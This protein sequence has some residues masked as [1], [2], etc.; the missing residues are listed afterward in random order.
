M[1]KKT[2]ALPVLKYTYKYFLFSYTSKSPRTWGCSISF[3]MA[4]SRSTFCNTDSVNLS[5][6]IIF[7]ATFFPWTQWVP[8]LTRPGNRNDRYIRFDND[9]EPFSCNQNVTQSCIWMLSNVSTFKKCRTSKNLITA[10]L[11]L[12]VEV[13]INIYSP[14][15]NT[16]QWINNEGNIVFEKTKVLQKCVWFYDQRTCGPLFHIVPQQHKKIIES[17]KEMKNSINLK[18]SL[19]IHDGSKGQDDQY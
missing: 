1:H 18:L 5:L 2:N 11:C 16:D 13:Y 8:I 9:D 19:L 15:H 4:I 12:Y 3:I 10:F 7:M 14:S 17:E 6:F